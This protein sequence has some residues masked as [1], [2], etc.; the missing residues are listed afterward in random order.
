[1]DKNAQN[2]VIKRPKKRNTTDQ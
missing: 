1:V 2:L